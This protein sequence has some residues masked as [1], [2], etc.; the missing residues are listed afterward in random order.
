M[1]SAGLYLWSPHATIRITTGA[2][3]GDA[4]RVI[5]VDEQGAIVDG[6]AVMTAFS[7]DLRDRGRLRNNAIAVTVMSNLGLRRALATAGIDIV[8]TPVGDRS[9]LVALEE[10]DLAMGGE[11]SGHII[12]A[13]LAT[14]GDGLLTGLLLGDL[15]L[16]SDRPLSALGA[17]MT[18]F[19]Q[20]LVSLRVAGPARLDDADALW[21]EVAAVEAEMGERGRVLIRASGTEALVRVMVEAETEAAAAAAVERLCG[22][23]RAAFPSP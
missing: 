6:D 20:R 10:H 14:T 5:A 11:Q 16:R 2:A 7:I 19:P 22:A 3:G 15:V 23:V 4:D 18:R 9:V 13:D 1:A 21:R 8:E 17:Q 12:F